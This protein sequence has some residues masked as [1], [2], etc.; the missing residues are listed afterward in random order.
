[1][2]V[3]K[4]NPIDI[5][6][7]VVVGTVNQVSR[8]KLVAQA[9]SSSVADIRALIENERAIITSLCSFG[10]D[11]T[12]TLLIV[13]EAYRQAIAAKT[14]EPER[15][16]IVSTVNTK[17]EAIPM[18]MFVNYASKRMLEYAKSV[19]I[20]IQF[21]LVQPSLNNEFFIRYVGGQKIP[22]T[23]TRSGDCSVILKVNP[24]EHFVNSLVE[25][26]RHSKK[27]GN[28]AS[29]PIISC[30]GSREKESSRRS[31]N[32][33]RHNLKGKSAEDLMN[34]MTSQSI[35][36]SKVYNYAPIRD[37]ETDDVFL[38]LSLAGSKP[39]QRSNYDIPGFLSNFGLLIEIYGNGTSETCEIATGQSGGAGCNGKARYGCSICTIVSKQD[40]TATNLAKL[41]RW[42]VL[43]VENTLRLRDWLFRISSNMSERALHARAFDPVGYNRVALQPNTLKPKHL[44]KIVRYA[45]QL[46]QES[47]AHSERFKS[48]VEQGREA[49]HEGV[50][51]IQNDLTLP[52]KIKKAFLEMYTEA[53]LNPK[54]LNYYFSEVH[55]VLLSFRWSL[56]GIGAAPFRPLAI[57]KQIEQGKGWIP[58]PKLN[59]EMSDADIGK[60]QGYEAL[61]EAVMMP[62]LRDEDA[63]KHVF[64]HVSLIDLWTRPL[65][66]SDIFDED[67]NCSIKR[68]SDH[69]ANV[70]AIYDLNISAGKLDGALSTALTVDGV[71]SLHKPKI[72]KVLFEGKVV[73]GKLLELILNTG[74]ENE[75][76]SY[77]IQKFESLL[78]SVPDFELNFEMFNNLVG[79]RKLTRSLKYFEKTNL[80][81]G[82]SE[83]ARKVPAKINFT[84]RVSKVNR[85]KISRGNTRMVF[86]PL[87]VD[88]RYHQAHKQEKEMFKLCFDTHTQKLIS[89][90]D[91][92]F[93]NS[94]EARENI[95][96]SQETVACWKEAG[97][98][99]RALELHNDYMH[100]LIKYRHIRKSNKYDVRKYPGTQAAEILITEGGVTIERKYL[101]QFQFL[102]KRTQVMDSLSMFKY[103]SMPIDVV[104]ASEG[105]I[106]MSQHRRD[107]AEVLNVIRKYRNQ[108]RGNVRSNLLSFDVNIDETLNA[109]DESVSIVINESIHKQNLHLLK[110]EFNTH[111]VSTSDRSN[112]AK[113]WLMMHFDGVS[114][115]EDLFSRIM[116]SKDVILVNNNPKLKVQLTTKAIKRLKIINQ[117]I[118]EAQQVWQPALVALAKFNN[119]SFRDKVSAKSEFSRLVHG[120]IGSNVDKWVLNEWNPRLDTLLS[121]FQSAQKNINSTAALFDDVVTTIN[122]VSDTGAHKVVAKMTFAQRLALLS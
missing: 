27:Y 11:S 106:A 69:S 39:L 77:C 105:A 91:K 56:D 45:C 107:K 66:A 50:Q 89:M 87:S 93:L 1:M 97:G 90:H 72:K 24:N 49:E 86:Y 46:T 71:V 44:D 116:T 2:S 102:L 28:Y 57:W 19:G 67:M 52:P 83:S 5:I 4:V 7:S 38:L 95:F 96:I 21:K 34:S 61:S 119:M 111:S 88:S 113:L 103:Q 10:K 118:L 110:A 81:T 115:I 40:K 55:A 13:M 31:K 92:D 36:N 32:M 22:A 94:D 43:G 48:L 75:V 122:K 3:F 15:P 82:Y 62:V 59:S 47:I 23:P 63:H 68:G 30:L 17:A 114:K 8:E 9:F 33:E 117:R 80:I 20:N 104:K 41:K 79:E 42:E 121:A 12:V 54:N 60:I 16:L 84:Q 25:S 65:D 112:A 58:Y 100:R 70:T 76:D 51:C 120:A 37:W 73:S 6:D 74:L 99:D 98:L 101:S 35:G 53:L 108:Q 29:S 26:I 109:L 85:K 78:V 18:Q 64:D 14:I